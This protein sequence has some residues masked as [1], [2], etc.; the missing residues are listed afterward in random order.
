M[1]RSAQS[2]GF[3]LC[4]GSKKAKFKWHRLGRLGAGHS[5]VI[6]ARFPLAL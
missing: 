3:F 5:E 6:L 1:R 2:L 4:V